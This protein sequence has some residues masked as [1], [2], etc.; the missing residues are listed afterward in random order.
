MLIY[1]E[2]IT[3]R[4]QYITDFIGEQI[5]G[6]SCR[7]TSNTFYFKDHKGPKINYSQAKICDEEFY[8]QNCELLFEQSIHEQVIS[9]FECN[10]FKAF[11]KT[12]GDYPFD[13]FASCFYLLTRYEEYLPHKKDE[14]GRYAHENSLAFREDFL[15]LPLINFWLDDFKKRLQKIFP[16]LK[17][18]HAYFNYIPTYDIDEA[19]A[20]KNKSVLK[21][22]GGFLKSIFKGQWSVVKSR[23]EVMLNHEADPYDAYDW[24]D[25]LH[26]KARL[27][28][29]YFFHTGLE[30]GRYDKN[31]SPL[32]TSMQKLISDHSA[33]YNIGIHPSWQSG[34]KEELL[35]EELN[36]LEKII[37]KKIT[38]SRQHFIRFSLP[39][40]FRRLVAAGIKEDFSMGYGSINGFRASVA[41]SFYW[42][43]LKK[44]SVTNLLLRPFCFM[45]ANSFFEQKYLP[46]RAFEEMMHYYHT[47]KAVNGQLIFIWHNNF[48]GTYPLFQ[49]W[50][51]VYAEFIN[52]NFRNT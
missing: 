16:E 33:K 1:A 29:I 46:Q 38:L 49:G 36:I 45:E 24:M 27:E 9:V 11:F 30:K 37:G 22:A 25:Q 32:E 44:E 12:N 40:T 20:F 48:L 2:K 23:W 52:S 17:L 41:S 51:E 10:D 21:N 5:T 13:I 39:H 7:L 3:S 35:S 14:Y 8:I 6:E 19:Y 47:V 15:H 18:R 43:D 31:I 50:K 4:L 34:D 28:P 42:Y 26:N